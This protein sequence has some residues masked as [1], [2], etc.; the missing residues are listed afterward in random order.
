MPGQHVNCLA[1]SMPKLC[2]FVLVKLH[3]VIN[4]NTC[5]RER[6]RER[7]G[8]YFVN[9]DVMN[10]NSMCTQYNTKCGCSKAFA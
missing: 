1:I 10:N 9:S 8:I 4:K 7:E 3:R 5:A 6:E 2:C